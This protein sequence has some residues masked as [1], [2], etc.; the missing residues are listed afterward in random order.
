MNIADVIEDIRSDKIA[1]SD[2]PALIMGVA[3]LTYGASSEKAERVC[4][5]LAVDARTEAAIALLP[6]GAVWRKYIDNG[7][8]VYGASPFNAAAQERFD[9]YSDN[10]PLAITAAFLRMRFAKEL[11]RERAEAKAQVQP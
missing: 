7:A 10:W 3:V 8:S 1:D 9:G 11:E 6:E 5:L 2:V 4:E